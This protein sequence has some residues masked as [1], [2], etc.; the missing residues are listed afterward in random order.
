MILSFFCLHLCIVLAL[1]F[2]SFSRTV[3]PSLVSLDV[4]DYIDIGSVYALEGTSLWIEPDSHGLVDACDFDSVTW[5]NIIDQVFVSTQVDG[6]WCFTFW[7]A[8][9]SFLNLDMLLIGENALVVNDLERITLLAVLTESR[10]LDSSHLHNSFF[11]SSTLDALEF[12]LLHLR[13]NITVANYDSTKCDQFVNMI[14]T[15]LSYPVD[16]P[17]VVRSDLDDRI[18][19]LILFEA[20]HVLV[21]LLTSGE[22]VH[23]ELFVGFRDDEI[24]DWNDISWVINNL[25]VQALIKLEDVITVNFEYALVKFTDFFQLLHVVAFLDV[26]LIILLVI[27]FSD[28]FKVVDEIFEFA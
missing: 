6:L 27:V 24:K 25:A 23:V 8:L 9:W 2:D 16:L 26:L 13:H 12:S 1:F 19:V 20:M 14:R 17:E 22:N 21:L 7:N 11:F 15:Q 28:L 5:L 18:H 3:V 4:S 10:L